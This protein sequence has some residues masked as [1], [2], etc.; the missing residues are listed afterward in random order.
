MRW[1]IETSFRALKYTVGLT[2][3]HAKR[4]ESIIQEIFARMILHNFAEM[5]TSHVIISQMDKR[6]QYQVNFTVAVHVCRHFL[7]SR[8]EEPPPD[9]KALIRKNILP[10]QP[11]R[12]G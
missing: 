7:R 9:I 4:Q 5:I 2:N 12:P 1:D 6:H 11:I 10:I 3:F 8:D